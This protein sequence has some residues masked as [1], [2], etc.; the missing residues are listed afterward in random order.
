MAATPKF[1]CSYCHLPL[2]D[3]LGASV[4]GGARKQGIGGTP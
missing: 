3:V 1:A 4:S 2:I